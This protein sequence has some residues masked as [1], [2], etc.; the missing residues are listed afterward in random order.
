MLNLLL[1]YVNAQNDPGAP[2]LDQCSITTKFVKLMLD[3]YHTRRTTRHTRAQVKDLIRNGSHLNKASPRA[4]E[5]RAASIAMT[6][7]A[8]R[9]L[10]KQPGGR[11]SARPPLT[12]T[13]HGPASVRTRR[14]PRRRYQ[15]RQQTKE[16]STAAPA[17]GARDRL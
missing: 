16:H 2:S 1:H 3:C 12:P 13:A 7:K 17:G 6:P 5:R 15:I 11:A 14:G 9:Q 10:Y 4:A 8:A